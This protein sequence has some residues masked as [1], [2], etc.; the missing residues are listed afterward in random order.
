MVLCWQRSHCR[1]AF[2]NMNY[3]KPSLPVR[4]KLA[5]GVLR[6]TWLHFCL[7]GYIRASHA[8]RQSRQNNDIWFSANPGTPAGA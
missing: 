2:E 6:R 7:P 5:W 4:V 1:N 3:I 8:S